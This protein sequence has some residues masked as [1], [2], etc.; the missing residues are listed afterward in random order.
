[1]YIFSTMEK[2][3]LSLPDHYNPAGLLVQTLSVK[4]IYRKMKATIRYSSK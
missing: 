2:K 3:K 1:M 4:P